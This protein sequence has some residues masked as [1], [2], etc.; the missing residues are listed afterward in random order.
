MISAKEEPVA[1]ISPAMDGLLRVHKRTIDG[2]DGESTHAS[3]NAG[4]TVSTRLLVAATQAGSLI[5]KQGATIKSIQEASS[6]TVRVLGKLSIFNYFVQQLFDERLYLGVL[7]L[8]FFF[9]FSSS[10]SSFALVLRVPLF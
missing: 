9:F 2:L 5:G 6:T 4:N 10:N 1:S 7:L 3:Q 8:S